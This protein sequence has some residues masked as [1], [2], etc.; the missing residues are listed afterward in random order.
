MAQELNI[1]IAT[2]KTHRRNLMRKLD[3]KNRAEL[4]RYAIKQQIIKI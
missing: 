1:S 4:I 2:V 3:L